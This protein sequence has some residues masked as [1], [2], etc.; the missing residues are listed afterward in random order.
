MITFSQFM[1]SCS[2]KMSREKYA[3]LK[4]KPSVKDKQ[5]MSL[6]YD[7]IF[8]NP[9]DFIE[10][11]EYII[12]NRQNIL[13]EQRIAHLVVDKNPAAKIGRRLVDE[14]VDKY[15]IDDVLEEAVKYITEYTNEDTYNFLIDQGADP[16]GRMGMIFAQACKYNN[17][18]A[19]KLFVEKYKVDTNSRGGMPIMLALRKNNI[20]IAKYLIEHGADIHVKQDMPI[21]MINALKKDNKEGDLEWLKTYLH[22]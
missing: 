21:K 14:F 15:M 20:G 13:T 2:T 10:E 11:I 12:S 6:L 5:S 7:T 16:N 17:I 4:W 8:F 22:S 1:F 3:Y 9:N 18:L 19:V